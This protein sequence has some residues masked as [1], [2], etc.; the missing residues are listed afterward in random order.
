MVWAL[1]KRRWWIGILVPAIAAIFATLW[2]IHSLERSVWA[3][4]G[5]QEE[6]YWMAVQYQ[7]ALGR[8]REVVRAAAAGEPVDADEA[9]L[10][11]EILRSRTALLSEPSEFT[12]SY[13]SVKGFQ[14]ARA[15][16]VWFQDKVLP[17]LQ[18]ALAQRAQAAALLA[19]FDAHKKT[20]SRLL[21]DVRTEELRLREA[22]L[23]AYSKRRT[24]GLLIV[25]VDVTVLVALLLGM[26]LQVER[27]RRLKQDREDALA[28]EQAAV[29]AKNLFLGMVSHELRSP[30]QGIVSG[31]DLLEAQVGA[32]R[33]IQGI[34][35]DAEALNAQLADLLT[36]AKGE[37]G[38]LEVRPQAF[39]AC[40]L[41]A[42][43]AERF[44]EP[45]RAKGLRL[46]VT[47]PQEPVFVVADHARIGQC[48]TNLISNAI[49]YTDQGRVEVQLFPYDEA[50]RSLHIEVRDTGPGLPAGFTLQGT[51]PFRRLAPSGG[52][53]RSGAGIGLVI[54]RLIVNHLGGRVAVA[55]P[56]GGGTVF[57]I[58]IPAEPSGM[59]EPQAPPGDVVQMLV[60]DDRPEVL[61]GLSAV[62]RQSGFH[63]E[64]AANAAVA[65]N[66]LAAKPYDVVLIDLNMPIKRGEDLAS[67][68]RRGG[69]CNSRTPMIAISASGEPAPGDARLGPFNAYLPKP[70]GQRALR[71]AVN[72]VM[73]RAHS[74]A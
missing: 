38:R 28:A 56:P 53:A 34:R 74:L 63:C 22:S 57:R 36:L 70:I 29:K 4:L 12:A 72:R 61:E 7:T 44:A 45:A 66:M 30:L 41:V 24:L 40:D 2:W 20:A 51:E 5:P 15:Q 48:L 27:E 55:S 73:G 52:A 17:R 23:V 69:G 37:A 62:A 67:E 26:L 54:V 39:E 60:V 43:L 49:K 59:G 13:Q 11:A 14:E 6:Y 16:L 21:N 64:Q 33:L 1:V 65:A 35:R 25:G 18:P 68:T 46:A 9:E 71:E 10:R 32:S 19:E 47:V 42:D 58:D 3:A 31:L 8:M 50:D